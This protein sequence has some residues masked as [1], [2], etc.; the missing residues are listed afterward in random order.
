[1]TPDEEIPGDPRTVF[2]PTQPSEPPAVPPPEQTMRTPP[3]PKT[4]APPPTP[5]PAPATGPPGQVEIGAVLNGIYE[6]KR[7]IARGG[8]R[9]GRLRRWG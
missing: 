4:S 6:V 7:H 3:E 5:A 2:M 1:M 8:R 9:W